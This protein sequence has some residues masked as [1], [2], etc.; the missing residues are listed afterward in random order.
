MRAT[1]TSET[2]RMAAAC[3]EQVQASAAQEESHKRAIAGLEERM[4]EMQDS[5][6]SEVAAM[7][8]GHAKAMQAASVT[9][10][11]AS[12]HAVKLKNKENL[13]TQVGLEEVALSTGPSTE[14]ARAEGLRRGM[15]SSA[16]RAMDNR[17]SQRWE[18]TH[19]IKA[20]Q[21]RVAQERPER[22][23]VQGLLGAG[24]L[25]WHGQKRQALA[26]G[27]LRM[28]LHWTEVT[29]AGPTT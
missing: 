7:K 18:P 9:L 22:I 19:S 3:K 2:A 20:N 10:S 21:L 11:E 23:T 29:A 14:D 27:W 6:S 17:P 25:M 24:C 13:V 16:L 5:H 12:L 15:A 28:R 4:A 8:D 26:V 1:H